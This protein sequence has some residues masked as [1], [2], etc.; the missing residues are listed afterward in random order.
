MV[1]ATAKDL[2]RPLA[3]TNRLAKIR[4]AVESLAGKHRDVVCYG[5]SVL[6]LWGGGVR[7]LFIIIIPLPLA[8]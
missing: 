6:V 1:V 8:H 5:L 3:I 2:V 7:C 4:I